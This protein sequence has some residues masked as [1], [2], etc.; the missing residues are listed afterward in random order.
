VLLLLL[1]CTECASLL[2]LL[3]CM[4]ALVHSSRR[5]AGSSSGVCALRRLHLVPVLRLLAED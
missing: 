3:R 5:R 1:G 2:L 4:L